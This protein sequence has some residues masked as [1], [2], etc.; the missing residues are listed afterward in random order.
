MA[1]LSLA[2]QGLWSRMLCWAHQ[3][4]EHR[5]FLELP[6]GQPMTEAQIALRV[7][8]SIREVRP[9]LEELENYNVFSRSPTGAIY[10]RRMARETHISSVRRAAAKSRATRAERESDG[11]FAGR[12]SGTAVDGLIQHNSLQPKGKIPSVTDSVSVSDISIRALGLSDEAETF[13][14]E[15]A[16]DKLWRAYPAKGRVKKPL[17]EQYFCDKVRTSVMT[18]RVIAAVTGKW[19]TS[20]KWAKG[21]VLSL[22]EWISQECWNE[23]PQQ[24]SRGAAVAENTMDPDTARRIRERRAEDRSGA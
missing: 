20:E 13:D 8:R 5:G 18:E 16:F 10:C 23:D 17:S 9:R 7:G 19:A 21:F 15:A 4:E 3:N 14:A 12:I 22:P 24:A 1:G 6:N 2:A 11:T